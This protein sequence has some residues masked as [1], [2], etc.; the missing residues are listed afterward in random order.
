MSTPRIEL[1]PL[2][3]FDVRS[4]LTDDERMVQDSVARLV[5]ERVIPVIQ[6]HFEDHTFP[7]ELVG[8]LDV[9]NV[10]YAAT[11]DENVNVVDL[12]ERK[13]RLA[14]LITQADILVAGLQSVPSRFLPMRR[15]CSTPSR[16]TTGCSRRKAFRSRRNG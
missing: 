12:D 4:Q 10:D 3:L 6:K 13:M 9:D 2:D 15:R 1:N 11:S 16:S 5:D 7:R 14:G 8:E